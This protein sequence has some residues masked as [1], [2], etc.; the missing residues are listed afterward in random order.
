MLVAPENLITA[1]RNLGVLG[2]DMQ[3]AHQAAAVPTTEI[4]TAASDEVSA[5]IA[6]I[7]AS[8]GQD[9]QKLA[10]QAAA[11]HDQFTQVLTGS[12]NAYASAEAA[13]AAVLSA[14]AAPAEDN[15]LVTLVQLG[16]VILSPFIVVAL[17][18]TLSTLLATYWAVTF[19]STALA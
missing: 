3:I 7:F 6:Q 5:A 8:H 9:F 1:A 4:A 19:L 16:A 14:A 13:N 12:A 17:L 15:A 11:F 10:G 18:G 2:S